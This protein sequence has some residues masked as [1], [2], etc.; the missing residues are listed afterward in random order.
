M[1]I[2]KEKLY[3]SAAG[4]LERNRL[5]DLTKSTGAIAY[6]SYGSSPDGWLE[7]RATLNQGAAIYAIDNLNTTMRL[8]LQTAVAVK[9]NPV[10]CGASG[11]VVG[12]L[13]YTV[14]SRTQPYTQPAGS[15]GDKYIA[16]ANVTAWTAPTQNVAGEII[17]KGASAYTRT[18]A[19]VGMLIY[20]TDEAR[21]YVCSAEN[22]WVLAKLVGYAAETGAAGEEIEV[23]NTKTRARIAS[24][25]LPA[26]INW[27][28]VL[29]GQG[30]VSTSGTTLV[31]VDERITTACVAVVTCVSA[32]GTAPGTIK[33]VL[34]T[35][36]LTVTITAPGGSDTTVLNYAIFK[37]L[38]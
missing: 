29:C 23:Y 27:A 11:Q 18:T 22:T 3:C 2:Q 4:T 16:P 26:N 9:G 15:N 34:T 1:G 20:V 14:I 19:T 36:T 8:K 10:F 6:S 31:I 7:E 21:Y 25:Q 28:P 24:E 5:V 30:T 33:A 13:S 32:S 35:S 12:T 37:Q 38:A 17:Q